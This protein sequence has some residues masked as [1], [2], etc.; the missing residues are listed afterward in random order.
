MIWAQILFKFFLK[1]SKLDNSYICITVKIDDAFNLLNKIIWFL[2]F[3]TLHITILR[4]FAE[5]QLDVILIHLF[6]LI[7]INSFCLKINKEQMFST[8]QD[9]NAYLICLSISEKL[10]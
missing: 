1:Q 2:E 7:S 3:S 8:A 6:F 9:Y 5:F 4:I 10:T